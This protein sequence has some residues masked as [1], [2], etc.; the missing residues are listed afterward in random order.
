MKKPGGAT[1]KGRSA[2]LLLRLASAMAR[3]GVPGRWGESV[4]EAYPPTDPSPL[5]GAPMPPL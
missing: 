4:A 1:R 5:R 3:H 2:G